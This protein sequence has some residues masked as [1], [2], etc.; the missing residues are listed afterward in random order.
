M[1]EDAHIVASVPVRW[2]F[3][4]S[5]MHTFGITENFFIIV[6]QPLTVSVPAVMKSQLTNKPMAT[7]LKWFENRQTLIYLLDRN[8]GELKYTFQAEAFFYLHII[9]QYEKDDHVVLDICC[10]KDPAMLNCMYV[11]HMK[12][13]YCNTA[14]CAKYQTFGLKHSYFIFRICK[15][16]LTMPKCSAVVHLDLCC[17]LN[18]QEKKPS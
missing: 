6:E 12:V 11:D 15:K 2:K 18:A 7:C 8:S 1:F 14:Y 10:Y 13:S 16:I 4:P 3:H 9:N 5:Y 17:R